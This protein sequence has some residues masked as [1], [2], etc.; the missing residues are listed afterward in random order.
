[1]KYIRN[2][3]LA[4]FGL[5][6]M[7]LVSS[8]SPWAEHIEGE[9][10][11]NTP[12]MEV[13]KSD[14]RFS[15]FVGLL[16]STAYDKVLNSAQAY[17]VFV[18]V[19]DA[20]PADMSSFDTLSYIKNHIA[21]QTYPLI[22]KVFNTD[23]IQMI[24]RKY[25]PVNGRNIGV[26]QI[27][28]E[29]GN[30]PAKNGLVHVM[31]RLIEP[32]L[33]ILEYLRSEYAHSTQ[34]QY[35][36]SQEEKI[37]DWEWSYQLSLDPVTGSPIY[38]TAWSYRNEWL[39]RYALA[40]EDSSYSFLVVSDDIIDQLKTL[41]KPYFKVGVYNP[42]TFSVEEDE[43]MTDSCL[44]K[45]V[46]QD[47]VLLPIE[48]TSG[49]ASV[50]SVDG[51]KIEVEGLDASYRA[52]NGWVYEP[53]NLEVKLYE[54]KIKTITIEAEAFDTH[55]PN[56][57]NYLS[58]RVKSWASGGYDIVMAGRDHWTK[59]IGEESI[60]YD[61]FFTTTSRYYTTTRNSYFEYRP[62]FHSVPY[63]A[64]WMAYDDMPAT[65][66]TSN[67]VTDTL[68]LAYKLFVSFPGAPALKYSNGTINNNFV[69]S[70]V[71]LG[72]NN[73]RVFEEQALNMW[74]T[75]GNYRTAS[76]QLDAHPDYDV[77][78]LPCSSYGRACVWIANSAFTETAN[79]A[80]SIYLD[81]I[82]FVPVID[83]NK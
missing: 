32:R 16:E 74:L 73:A 24:N 35:I 12:L 9:K 54:N 60:N 37:V 68:N 67:E 38:D 78:Q 63:K 76:K 82:K 33:N 34:V 46:M 64:Y 56:D 26:E 14:A 31:S 13:L 53:I 40:D 49:G 70:L 19:N 36:E 69:D 81:Y 10:Q 7:S 59:T 5:F 50:V 3:V 27:A 52:S 83:P 47:M 15:T 80:G 79:Y 44:L 42:L 8:C 43:T 21:W 57:N 2:F 75:T 61:C 22:Q 4:V 17:T 65:I 25:L 23:R 18:P 30:I 51:L 11:N 45:E 55:Y 1:M 39:N 20:F 72:Q 58:K 29:E 28:V 77:T 48:I 41:Y 62:V 71:F 66:V 6:W